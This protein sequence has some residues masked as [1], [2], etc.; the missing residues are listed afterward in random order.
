MPWS[1]AFALLGGATLWFFALAATAVVFYQ[2]AAAFA[3]MAFKISRH[4]DRWRLRL[5]VLQVALV[6]AG[7]PIFTHANTYGPAT[8]GPFA[9][10]G[11]GLKGLTAVAFVGGAGVVLVLLALNELIGRMGARSS[12]LP[13]APL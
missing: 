2:A 4:R 6:S 10:G 5:A 9:D 12:R 11:N 13:E 3:F 7:I 1:P 8:Q